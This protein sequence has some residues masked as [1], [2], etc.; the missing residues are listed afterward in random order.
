MESIARVRDLNVMPA[1]FA[2]NYHSSLWTSWISCRPMCC[3]F[4]CLGMWISYRLKCCG[5]QHLG[6]CTKST[7]LNIEIVGFDLYA[8]GFRTVSGFREFRYLA[9]VAFEWISIIRHGFRFLGSGFRT[10]CGFRGF[11]FLGR[12]V[13]MKYNTIQHSLTERSSTREK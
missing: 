2:A 11:R 9:K 10:F 1:S 13:V 6:A 7:C 8:G 4:R 3:G 12:P 5:P